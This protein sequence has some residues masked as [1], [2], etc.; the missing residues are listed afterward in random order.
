MKAIRRRSGN[1]SLCPIALEFIKWSRLEKQSSQ[2]QNKMRIWGCGMNR[3]MMAYYAGLA[4]G[5]RGAKSTG[6]FLTLQF[7]KLGTTPL[8]PINKHLPGYF[9]FPRAN[10][11]EEFC[12]HR[13][14][15]TSTFMGMQTERTS[16][17]L[18]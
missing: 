17:R 14:L 3:M 10:F 8:L 18:I 16:E 6:Q 1:A 2:L 15:I 11:C 9:T 5:Q 13:A 12:S 4:L 7:I